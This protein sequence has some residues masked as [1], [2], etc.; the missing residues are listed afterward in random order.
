MGGAKS[1]GG[2]SRVVFVDVFIEQD[3]VCS[4]PVARLCAG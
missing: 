3:V 2:T 1:P 4:Q